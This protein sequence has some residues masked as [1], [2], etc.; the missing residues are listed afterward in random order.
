MQMAE[1]MNLSRSA[2]MAVGSLLQYMTDTQKTDLSH[3]NTLRI[4]SG[5]EDME[6][7]LDT[8]LESIPL[9][10]SSDSEDGAETL[11]VDDP[12]QVCETMVARPY[13]K[14][15]SG[16]KQQII[17]GGNPNAG[18]IC[19]FIHRND[20][21]KQNFIALRNPAPSVQEYKMG[22]TAY[23]NLLQIYPVFRRIRA[24]E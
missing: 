17:S 1:D 4:N 21:K 19:G 24:G 12:V 22:K 20:R 18:E 2:V 5:E 10:G 16:G 6:L 11:N 14:I 8:D 15:T 7:D 23:G 3:I 9:E 13:V